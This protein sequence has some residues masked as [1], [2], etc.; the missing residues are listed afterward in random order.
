MRRIVLGAD[1]GTHGVRVLAVSLPDCSVVGKSIR[2]YKQR[3]DSAQDLEQTFLEALQ[4]LTLPSHTSVAGLGITHQRGTVIPVDEDCRPLATAFSDSDT[5][6]LDAAGFL[7]QGIDPAA[8]YDVSGCPVVSFNGFAKVLWC[9]ENI[10]ALFERAAAWLSP[11]DYLLSRLTGKLQMSQGSALRSGFLNVRT[12]RMNT[13]L[14]PDAA[15]LRVPCTPVGECC[16]VAADEWAKR[17]PLLKQVPLYAVPGDQ[18]AAVLGAGAADGTR[19]VMN[20]GTT[21]VTSIAGGNL[22]ADQ[23]RLITT[24]ILPLGFYSPEFGTGAGGQFMDFLTRT[25]WGETPQDCLSWS[26]FDE[27]AAGVPAGAEGLRIVPLLWQAT[28]PGVSGRISGLRAEHTRAHFLRAAY[29]G[30]SYEA[31]I[32][33]RKMESVCGQNADTIRVFGGLSACR[34]FLQILSSVSGKTVEATGEQQA[35]AYGAALTVAIGLGVFQTYGELCSLTGWTTRV[36]QP[37][38]EECDRYESEFERYCEQR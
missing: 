33:V 14:L 4:D 30:L 10:P 29:E 34:T 17:V 31:G 36:C 26:R 28:S 27:L 3:G 12:R 5:R 21:F 16:G 19:M 18:P 13:E 15:F 23:D 24:E 25:L 11:Q 2:F 20:L 6:A 1:A 35:S 22:C 32:A 37:K 38:A 9:R 7:R 8:Y